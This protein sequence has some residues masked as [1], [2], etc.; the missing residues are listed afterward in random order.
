MQKPSFPLISTK[1]TITFPVN[2]DMFH[3][4]SLTTDDDT[5]ILQ[6]KTGVLKRWRDFAE[7]FTVSQFYFSGVIF[8]EVKN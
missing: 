7:C 5:V 6:D 4:S 8:S 1:D 3:I 2:D